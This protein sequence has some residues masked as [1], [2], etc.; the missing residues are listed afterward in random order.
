MQDNVQ[1]AAY[2]SV[3]GQGAGEQQGDFA[4][5]QTAYSN[6]STTE[7]QQYAGEQQQGQSGNS[8]VQNV[9]YQTMPQYGVSG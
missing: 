9:Q 6:V 1:Y 3:P 2:G 5:Q 7:D 8:F 4:Y